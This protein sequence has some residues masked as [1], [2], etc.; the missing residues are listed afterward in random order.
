MFSSLG[1]SQDTS[2]EYRDKHWNPENGVYLFLE[3]WTFSY[4]NEFYPEK[5]S[6]RSGEMSFY[7]DRKTGTVL[8]TRG[9]SYADEMTDW[10]LVLPEGKYIYQWTDAHDS[11]HIVEESVDEY[12][13]TYRRQLDMDVMS[14]FRMRYT[15]SGGYKKYGKSEGYCIDEI[16]A[17]KYAS[18]S[19]L[20]DGEIET[21]IADVPFDASILYGI[22]NSKVVP[23]GGFFFP[24]FAYAPT[25]PS[26]HLVVAEKIYSGDKTISFQ[27]KCISATDYHLHIDQ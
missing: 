15:P 18:T 2:S 6:R 14:N 16:Q 24:I 5:D 22:H 10:I 27:L 13:M 25:I 23:E 21:Y 8:L 7:M 19:L 20:Y 12:I 9:V 3:L 4:H 1:Q 17:R 11:I 26:N